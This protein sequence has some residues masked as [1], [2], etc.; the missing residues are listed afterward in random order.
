MRFSYPQEI[1]KELYHP[2]VKYLLNGQNP[3]KRIV[4]KKVKEEHVKFFKGM[5]SNYNTRNLSIN[6][7]RKRLMN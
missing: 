3:Q 6:K 7:K 4:F 2:L 1:C 5:M